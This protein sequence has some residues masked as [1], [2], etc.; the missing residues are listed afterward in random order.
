VVK[1][2]LDG[3]LNRTQNNRKNMDIPSG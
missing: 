2:M 1:V 3:D